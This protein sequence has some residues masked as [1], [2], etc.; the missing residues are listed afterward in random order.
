MSVVIVVSF[1]P[2]PTHRDELIAAIDRAARVFHTEHGCERFTLSANDQRIV[3]IEKWADQQALQAHQGTTRLH[4]L[5]AE[6]DGMVIGNPDIQILT[7]HSLGE[8]PQGV[9]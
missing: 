9:L 3:L 1:K 4:E 5:F 7:P 6:I 2:D 8:A